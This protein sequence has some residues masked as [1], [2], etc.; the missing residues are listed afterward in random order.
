MEQ[1]DW[2]E[3][4]YK[5]AALIDISGPDVERK[6]GKKLAWSFDDLDEYEYVIFGKNDDYALRRY[7]RSP[8]GG[9]TLIIREGDAEYHAKQFNGFIEEYGVDSESVK[10]KDLNEYKFDQ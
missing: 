2:P 5:E 8:V 4:L 6:T 3:G 7:K 10:W 9:F 1:A